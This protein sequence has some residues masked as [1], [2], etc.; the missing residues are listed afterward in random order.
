MTTDEMT[1]NIRGDAFEP[2]LNDADASLKRLISNMLEKKSTEGTLTI[3]VDI[4]LVQGWADNLDPASGEKTRPVQIPKLTH[5]VSSVMQIKDETKGGKKY[6][7]YE[8][9]LDDNTGDYVMRPIE[10]AQQTIWNAE[11]VEVPVE[12]AGEKGANSADESKDDA[13]DK[14]QEKEGE[15][16]G[17]VALLCE[18]NEEHP[19]PHDVAFP[20]HPFAFLR[21]FIG[22]QMRVFEAMGNYTVR[23]KA[24]GTM[25]NAVVLSSA[26]DPS[27]PL[28][29]SAE[30][31]KP[32]VG[33]LIVC[34]GYWEGNREDEIY[35]KDDDRVRTVALICADCGELFFKL[36]APEDSGKSA[37][38]D[39]TAQEAN[40][41]G[42]ES[43]PTDGA[44]G[45]GGADRIGNEESSDSA[46]ESD[47]EE[48]E[49]MSDEFG[50]YPYENPKE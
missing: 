42:R 1:L 43:A 16:A 6:D 7:G 18:R 10:T 41:V 47:G 44:D 28:Y 17:P 24:D 23:A 38:G 32:H 14:E 40:T 26:Y 45:V 21:Q 5:K 20:E 36:D 15:T 46:E 31:L 19:T 34:A 12:D 3:K 33:H 13:S 9:V 25:F 50:G 4:E 29:C 37:E 2:V 39:D 11:Y 48:P 30:M 8:L 22:D 49:D 35:E 27:S